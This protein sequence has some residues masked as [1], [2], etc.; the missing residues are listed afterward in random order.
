MGVDH[1][2]E[3]LR[4]AADDAD[5]FTTLDFKGNVLQCPEGFPPAPAQRVAETVDQGLAQGQAAGNAAGDQMIELRPR[6]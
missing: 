1:L 6:A 4:L 5:D 2:D 3:V